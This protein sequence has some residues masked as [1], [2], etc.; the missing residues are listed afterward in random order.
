MRGVE[1]PMSDWS[2]E[3]LWDRLR[4]AVEGWLDED[5][6]IDDPSIV[7]H[8]FFAAPLFLAIVI[9]MRH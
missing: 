4:R 3:S 8:L 6:D 2:P 1:R 7:F 5:I 9:L